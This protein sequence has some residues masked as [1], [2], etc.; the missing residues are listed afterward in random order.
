VDDAAVQAVGIA[1]HDHVTDSQ[2][3]RVLRVD[4]G[5]DD[6]RP[7]RETRSHRAARHH[8]ARPR[9]EGERDARQRQR[10]TDADEDPQQATHRANLRR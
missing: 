2:V 10:Q 7:D 9:Q 5:G 1:K 3:L 4:R 8:E 6:Q